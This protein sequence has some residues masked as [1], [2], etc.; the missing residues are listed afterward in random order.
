MV[1]IIKTS[2][3]MI[4]INAQKGSFNPKNTIL[5][6]ALNNNWKIKWYKAVLTHIWWK[7]LD[8]T[9]PAETPIIIYNR[10]QTGAKISLGGLKLG[11]SN[12]TYQSAIDDL[13]AKPDK[14]PMT[15]HAATAI[16]M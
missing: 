5:Q 2:K 15:K 3:V 12:A 11:F 16:P 14:K 8:H 7:P 13:V 1:K 9:I 4:T 10:V 6:R